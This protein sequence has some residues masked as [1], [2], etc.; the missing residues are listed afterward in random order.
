[1]SNRAAAYHTQ[2]QPTAARGL[3]A[4]PSG[5]PAGE[6]S[7]LWARAPD[8]VLHS[9]GHDGVFGKRQFA[10]GHHSGLLPHFTALVL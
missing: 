5:A 6:L 10:A 9:Q 7:P 4:G 3:I 8:T 2:P 1:M